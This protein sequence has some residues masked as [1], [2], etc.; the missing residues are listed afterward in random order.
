MEA[1]QKLE[2]GF[3]S[4]ENKFSI[5]ESPEKHRPERCAFDIIS[6]KDNNA[7]QLHN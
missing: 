6:C 7:Y 2:S 1:K 3:K 5:C 4:R